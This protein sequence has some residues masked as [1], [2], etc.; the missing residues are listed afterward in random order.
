MHVQLFSI[1]GQLQ[2]EDAFLPT[3]FTVLQEQQMDMMLGLDMLRRHQCCI[4][5]R[6]NALLIGTTGT[7]TPFLPEGEL[8]PHARLNANGLA[9]DEDAQLAEALQKSAEDTVA[10]AAASGQIR[11]CPAA[12]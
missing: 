10:Q 6:K 3:S 2:I 1:L 8:P 4:D 5:L 12:I 11:R 9:M 7:E